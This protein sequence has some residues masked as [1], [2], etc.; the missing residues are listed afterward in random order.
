MMSTSPK[1]RSLS[2]CAVLLI[3]TLACCGGA[4]RASEYE[5]VYHATLNEGGPPLASFQG[6]APFAA[7]TPLTI[8]ANFDSSTADQWNIGAYFYTAPSATFLIGSSTYET[9]NALQILL[10]DPTWQSVGGPYPYSAGFLGSGP[11]GSITSLFG[12]STN[13]FD[14]ANPSPTKFYEYEHNFDFT[15]GTPLS[16]FVAGASGG[17]QLVIYNT[18]I[19][20]V[21]ATIFA[22]P[23]VSTWAMVAFGF[24]GL[25]MA[26][27]LREWRTESRAASA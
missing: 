3:S 2:N 13:P 6:S 26:G 22:V 21:T 7:G 5:I 1:S 8:T 10:S 27:R 11:L 14:A 15:D 12:A 20:D 19:S 23:E 9:E 25:G 18:S 4:A 16:L 17:G 24:A